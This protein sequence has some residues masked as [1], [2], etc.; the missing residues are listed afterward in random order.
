MSW[1]NRFKLRFNQLEAAEP[2][3]I[4]AHG[5]SRWRKPAGP[6]KPRNGLTRIRLS[7]ILLRYMLPLRFS[8]ILA[9]WFFGTGFC[10]AAPILNCVGDSITAGVGVP[11][12]LTSIPVSYT[13]LTLPTT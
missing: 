9:L 11:A 12:Q 6:A 10:G 7:S 4:A 13:H 8:A 1:P 2:R 3:P 5:V